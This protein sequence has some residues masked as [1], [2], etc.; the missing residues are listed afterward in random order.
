MYVE[1][2]LNENKQVEFAICKVSIDQLAILQKWAEQ[3]NHNLDLQYYDK[4]SDHVRNPHPVKHAVLQQMV[5]EMDFAIMLNKQIANAV[6]LATMNVLDAA[7]QNP[8]G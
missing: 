5:T 2:A 6:V 4:Q 7:M 3:V 1:N 8:G